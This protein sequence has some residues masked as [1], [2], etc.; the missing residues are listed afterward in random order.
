VGGKASAL[1][2]GRLAVVALALEELEIARSALERRKPTRAATT[3][4]RA[5]STVHRRD[6]G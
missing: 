4:L 5:P 3:A 2:G 1:G 6:R